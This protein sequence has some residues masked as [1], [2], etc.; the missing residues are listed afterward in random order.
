MNPY[1]NLPPGTSNRDIDPK[2]V[3]CPDCEGKGE[4]VDYDEE[5]FPGLC[6]CMRCLGS[7][8]INSTLLTPD[9]Q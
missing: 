8:E 3:E 9:E 6:K 1:S 4:I 7:G 5:D 2:M